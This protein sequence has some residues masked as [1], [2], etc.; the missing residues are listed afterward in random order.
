MDSLVVLHIEDDN[1]YHFLFSQY[2]DDDVVLLWG[3][4][5]E[6]T[7]KHLNERKIDIIVFDGIIPGWDGHIE[8]VLSLVKDIPYIVLSGSDY[9]KILEFKKNGHPAYQKGREGM[10]AVVEYIKSLKDSRK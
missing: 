9:S 8:E 1:G 4:G 5:R 7:L 2:L 3:V 6:Q 10:A